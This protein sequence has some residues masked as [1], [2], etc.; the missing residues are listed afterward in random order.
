MSTI[1][2]AGLSFIGFII[3]YNTYGRFLSRKLF[4]LAMDE[5]VPSVE[6]RDDI[7]YAPTNRF[8]LFGHHFTAIAGTG[9]IVGP[10]IAVLWGWLPALLWVVFGSIFIGAVHDFTALVLSL[11]NK[12]QTLGDIAG[13]VISPTARLLFLTLLAFLLAL[14]L[15]VFGSIIA[16]IFDEYPECV[17]SV[18]ASIPI[19]MVLGTLVYKSQVRIL[20]P[21]LVSLV[22]LYICAWL[23]T[24]VFPPLR[25]AGVEGNS[26]L[27]PIMIWIILL[28]IY[29]FFASTLPV[30]LLLQPRDYINSHQL[31]VVMLLVV[32]GLFYAGFS[33]K[34]DVATAAPMIRTAAEMEAKGMPPILPFL[35]IIV[36]CGAASGFHA[37]VAS[38]TTSKQVGNIAD[39]QFIGYG[40]ML[41]EGA[42][43]VIVII[44]CTAGIGLGTLGSLSIEQKQA[45]I[46]AH[47]GETD[48]AAWTLQAGNQMKTGRDAW[49]AWYDI[50]WKD[51]K[52]GK[53]VAVFIEGGANFMKG[54]GV[55]AKFA[56]CLMAMMIAC[57]AATTID[58]ATRLNRYVLQELGGSLHIAP[59]KNRY[60]STLIAIA[61]AI[62]LAVCRP[63]TVIDGVLK[64]GDYGAGGSIL[65][66]IFGS[67]N[68]VVV[69]LTL[70]VG[71]VYLFRRKA[72]VLYLLLPGMIM[73][74]IPL[75]G[76]LLSMQGF[77]KEKQYLLLGVG[78]LIACVAVWL[79]VEACLAMRRIVRMA[80]EQQTEPS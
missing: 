44:A 78:V 50:Q 51:M 60:V 59:M 7:D 33:G 54:I 36:A 32:I 31:Y 49:D 34:A 13:K 21:S 66:P 8:V 14:V 57:F 79:I 45:V 10:A 70:L 12:G 41:L 16:Q 73:L 29:C 1:L 43:A 19:A 61:L 80:S 15:A 37:L 22:I 72:R 3:A 63:V 2:I 6:F 69:G 39:A 38:G 42:L 28:F 40:A 55:P 9:P 27:N 23:G 65:W 76:M 77:W 68:Q 26:F 17:L 53:Q 30:W 18:W 74:I 71:T 64:Y 4:A 20:W 62:G 5:K 25:I 24:Y 75:W 58:C 47:P 52:L 67:G 11:R 46:A 56:F 35:F 48:L